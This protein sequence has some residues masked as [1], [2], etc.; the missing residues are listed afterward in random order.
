MRWPRVEVGLRCWRETSTLAW[1]GPR[2]IRSAKDVMMLQLGMQERL[3]S[4]AVAVVFFCC[5]IHHPATWP[6]S[7]GLL[8]VV[9]CH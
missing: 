6:Y 8:L 1:L 7:R 5:C 3:P 4:I 9:R 2:C